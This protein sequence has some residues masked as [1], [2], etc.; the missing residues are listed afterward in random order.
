MT[1]LPKKYRPQD[2]EAHWKDQWEEA[3]D[4]QWQ[5]SADRENVFSVDTPPPTVSGSLHIGHVF[6]Y[7]HTDALARYQRMKGKDVCYPMG[8][9]DNGLPT[10][11]RV[12]NV[13][14]I[15][16]DATLAYD[17]S[18]TY[19]SDHKRKPHEFIAVS[20]Q[21]FI[22]ACEQ[23]TTEDEAVFEGVWRRLGLSVDWTLRYETIND[24]CRAISQQSFLEC[25]EKGMVKHVDAPGMWDVDFQTAVAQAEIEDRP[26][27]GAYHHI[28]FDV[29][30][31]EP[32][33]IATTRPEL[34]PACIAVVVHPEDT[35]YQ[36]M[37]GKFAITPLFHARVPI[38]ASTHADPEKG[39]GVVM[40]CTFGDADDV[41]WW[42]QSD[43]PLK[44][45]LGRDGC[46]MPLTFGQ[47]PFSSLRAT[48]AQENYDQ[49]VGKRAKKARD[50]IVAL[51]QQENSSVDGTTRALIKEPERIEHPVKFYEKGDS[52]V[53]LIPTRQWF[54]DILSSKED[55]KAQG[56]KIQWH[57]NFMKTRYQHWVEGL[58]QDWCI[59]RQ[60]FFGVPFPV[61]YP[62]DDQGIVDYSS[63]IFATK[64]QCPVD[65]LTQ[66]P[67]GYQPDQRDKP[68][69]FTG[70]PDV[71]DT[72]ATSSL[73]PQL[74]SH[75]GKDNSR[76]ESIFPM[77]IRPQSHEIIRTWAFYT[78][79][80]AWIHEKSIPWKNVVISG[81]V[82]DPYRK[83]MSKSKGNVI[84][85]EYL[86]DQYSADAI[87]YW[88]CKARLGT[89]TAFDE[90]VFSVG[91][92]LTTKLFNA[93]KFVILQVSEIE[94]L[95]IDN[96]VHPL[97]CDWMESVYEAVDIVTDAYERFDYAMALDVTEQ[98][99]WTFCDH[100][101]ELVKG[102][103]YREED[104]KMRLSACATLLETLSIL[105]RLF[106]PV[107]PFVTEE[108]WSWRFTHLSHS[109]HKASWPSRPLAD[110]AEIPRGIFECAKVILNDIRARK[111][112]AQKNMKFPV[113]QLEIR[114]NS[115]FQTQFKHAEGDIVRAG[116]VAST[117]FILQESS[118]KP[119]IIITL[120]D[121]ASIK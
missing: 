52:P 99:F 2:R 111:T 27:K 18:V 63:P 93:A 81:W 32:C 22:E 41:A 118:E 13:Y 51:L 65:P 88:A 64:E 87:R 85:P 25:V 34:L 42:K 92:K 102:R 4:Y 68:L 3:K 43:L 61:W 39:T 71:M 58:N 36:S 76:H 83:K 12:Q 110:T 8:W 30:S 119:E 28:R 31:G 62:I 96:I 112:Q 15:R 95:S 60:R 91:Q 108:I 16:C 49:L 117:E 86:M 77:D 103:A 53:E 35:R 48:L 79:V 29:E 50:V 94:S 54:I 75:W 105:C 98:T 20:R 107:V 114:G 116:T 10:E 89:D 90:G 106:A 84:T 82:L 5:G 100:Y 73:T 21:N 104:S 72:W 66:C 9:D 33:I 19:S 38:L 44:Q 23:L 67:K 40:I 47:E 17:D 78:I 70:D 69:G 37:V 7:T 80:K 11:R 46:L 120:A 1:E 121:G 109:I 6:S 45:I 97:D 101:I 59:S 26:M 113:Q 24:H 115:I 55:L 56:D 57:P 14:G 74:V